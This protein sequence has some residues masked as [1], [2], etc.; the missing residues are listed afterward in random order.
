MNTGNKLS[1]ERAIIEAAF[2]GRNTITE[3]AAQKIVKD[4]QVAGF[5]TISKHGRRNRYQ[6]NKRK[7]L[8]HGLES[9]CNVGKVLAL[10]AKQ[11]KTARAKAIPEPAPVIQPEPPA[12][13]APSNEVEVSAPPPSETPAD[14]ESKEDPAVAD[15]REQRS[16]F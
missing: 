9:H 6:I 3:R 2:E 10:V 12:E 15:T 7:S 16:L 13:L 8:R 1:D 14:A 11:P 4:M 5:L